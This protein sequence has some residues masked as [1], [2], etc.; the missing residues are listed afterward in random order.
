MFS[1]LFVSHVSVCFLYVY[2]FLMFPICLCRVIPIW[3]VWT[4]PIPHISVCRSPPDLHTY[5][6]A[7]LFSHVLS[8]VFMCGPEAGGTSR[9]F[10]P[11]T[12]TSGSNT[13]SGHMHACRSD[14]SVLGAGCDV[15]ADTVS[16]FAPRLVYKSF[17]SER[18][19][20]SS[21]PSTVA[22]H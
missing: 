6:Q 11:L 9:F 12:R 5:P 10:L 18:H 16:R 14:A 21:L 2:L 17:V 13:S 20:L 22:P 3:I 15:P 19:R 7:C 8:R 4:F 1:C